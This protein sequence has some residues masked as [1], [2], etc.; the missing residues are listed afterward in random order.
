[1]KPAADSSPTLYYAWLF[2]CRMQI[3]FAISLD[4]LRFNMMKYYTHCN[5]YVQFSKVLKYT[6]NTQHACLLLVFIHKR[7]LPLTIRNK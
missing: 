3:T 6:Q 7:Y 4:M 5:N 2:S 1:M